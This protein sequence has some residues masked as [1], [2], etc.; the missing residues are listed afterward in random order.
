M[1]GNHQNLLKRKIL[2]YFPF[3]IFSFLVFGCS[4]WSC[5]RYSPFLDDFCLLDK[6]N[7]KNPFVLFAQCQHLIWYSPKDFTWYIKSQTILIKYTWQGLTICKMYHIRPRPFGAADQSFIQPKIEKNVLETLLDSR[8]PVLNFE[9]YH[10]TILILFGTLWWH[11]PS[12]FA[13]E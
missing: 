7:K 13:F 2:C 8:I 9:F 10:G 5:V 1:I 3:S 4:R 11:Y 12:L 6:L